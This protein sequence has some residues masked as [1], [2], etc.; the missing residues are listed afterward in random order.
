MGKKLS[1]WTDTSYFPRLS[2]EAV[3]ISYW[4]VKCTHAVTN[5]A[6]AVKNNPN[7]RGAMGKA[8]SCGVGK[9]QHST[10]GYFWRPSV[11]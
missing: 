1:W 10:S 11:L 8:S 3:D 4:L 2:S 9:A 6:K 7:L 5:V